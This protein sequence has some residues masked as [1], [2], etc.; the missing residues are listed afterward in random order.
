MIQC[1]LM[2]A[3]CLCL[4]ITW[5]PCHRHHI[6]HHID[7]Y[8]EN[9][10][11]LTKNQNSISIEHQKLGNSTGKKNAEGGLRNE[12]VHKKWKVK[13]RWPC[14]P[15]SRSVEVWST[16]LSGLRTLWA[17]CASFFHHF[18]WFFKGFCHNKGREEVLVLFIVDRAIL[19]TNLQV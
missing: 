12:K 5:I 8:L 16:G 19:D 13:E 6:E 2:I 3:S 11:F 7:I 9:G 14:W 17:S 10:Q 4:L 1:F 18:L 15:G